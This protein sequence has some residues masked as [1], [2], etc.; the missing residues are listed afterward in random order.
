MSYKP[1]VLKRGDDLASRKTV[2]TPVTS[3]ISA[4]GQ[5]IPV[6]SFVAAVVPCYRE[7][8][9]IGATLAAMPAS[10]ARI[11]VVDDASPDG[12]VKI[13]E[14]AARADPRIALI[15]HTENRGVGA[16]IAT[17]Y[18]RS[19]ED[20]V[21]IAV[22]MAGDGQ[23]KPED[24]PNLLKPV[25]EGKADYAKGNRFFHTAGLSGMPRHRLIG[26]LV[27]S[28]LTKI[29]SGYWHVSDTQCGYTAINRR[30]LKAI[31]WRQLYPRYGCPN[32]ILTRLNVG[33]M[34]V[35]EVSVHPVYGPTWTSSMKIGQTI[36]PILH[37]FIRL[38]CFRLYRK[39]VYMNGHPIVVFYAMAA[40]FGSAGIFLSAYIV[41][42]LIQTGILPQGA[43]IMFGIAASA[44]IQLVLGAFTLDYQANEKLAVFVSD[45]LAS[46]D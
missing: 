40:L 24:L 12:S 13:I 4:Q 38:F 20:R 25:L 37:L 35:A 7:E 5:R 8:A 17:G 36:W 28:L 22:V 16:A 46:N 44:T 33:N 30:A 9:K 14:A 31:E 41:L 1:L 27:L 26:N 11:Y 29:V 10:L 15:R 3:R 34:R 2:A 45:D 18:M 6:A 19:I 21:D 43:L 42:R 39:Y 23:M 32:D